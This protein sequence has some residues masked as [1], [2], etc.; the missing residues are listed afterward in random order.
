MMHCRKYNFVLIDV[1][2]GILLTFLAS[3][4]AKVHVCL[5]QK[6]AFIF[7]CLHVKVCIFHVSVSKYLL[8]LLDTKVIGFAGN[9]H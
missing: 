4:K 1:K 6:H 5:Y 9:L 7:G 3:M 2:V 8:K